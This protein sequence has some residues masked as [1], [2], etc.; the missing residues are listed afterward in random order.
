MTKEQFLEMATEALEAC[1][2]THRAGAWYHKWMPEYVAEYGIPTTVQSS[3][4]YFL[5][6]HAAKL[7]RAAE[8][9]KDAR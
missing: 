3:L 6:E 8:K 2:D 4:T 5:C 7:L 1:G 9:N